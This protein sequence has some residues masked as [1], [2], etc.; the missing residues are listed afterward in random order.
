MVRRRRAPVF[1]AAFELDRIPRQRADDDGHSQRNQGVG[2]PHRYRQQQDD[3]A[4]EDQCAGAGDKEAVF[5]FNSAMV[6]P[7]SAA[8]G[9]ASDMMAKAMP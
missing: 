6:T 7:E 8:N 1:G 9:I 5:A 2:K 4:V 3:R